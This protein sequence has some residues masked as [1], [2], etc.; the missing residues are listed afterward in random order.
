MTCNHS[1]QGGCTCLPDP[2]EKTY[3]M[4]YLPQAH[5]ARPGE[6]VNPLS[7]LPAPVGLLPSTVSVYPALDS[8]LGWCALGWCAYLDATPDEI[9]A[10]CAT[11]NIDPAGYGLTL[12]GA[13]A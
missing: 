13:D 1:K 5:H 3:D 8:A 6:D 11:L 9:R 10:A 7:T 12:E 4:S 2:E